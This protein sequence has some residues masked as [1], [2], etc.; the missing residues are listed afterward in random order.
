LVTTNKLAV[1]VRVAFA[2]AVAL[3]FVFAIGLARPSPAF[4]QTP[5]ELKAARELFQEAFK[6]EQEKRYPEALDKFQRVARVK[7]SSA[8]RYRIATVLTAMGRL[9]E[10]RDM[11]R[12]LAVTKSASQPVAD[13]EIADSSAE[14]ATELDRRIPKL[15]IRLQDNPPADAR[16]TV[17]GAP[18]PVSTTPRVIEL[19]PGDHV[20]AATGRGMAPSE[21]TVTLNDGAGEVAHTVVLAPPVQE[22]PPPPPKKDN[23][24]AWVAIGGGSALI[25]TGGVLL[26]AREGAINEIKTTCPL[27]VCPA[28]SR[29]E[30][31]SDISRAE[32][33][34]PLGV[35]LDLVGLAAVGVGV[36][37][38]VRSPPSSQPPPNPKEPTKPGTAAKATPPYLVLPTRRGISLQLTF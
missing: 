36:Y 37:W 3:A 26:I 34:G 24:L 5:D 32:L 12:S 7:E 31:E 33:F 9:R 35:A 15:A 19:D 6:D 2:F 16:V 8:V 27:R 25:L 22:P 11:Y 17:D 38:L 28:S 10:A 29:G 1:V 21:K 4:A 30:V 14:K 20:V 23:T 13:Q 18:V